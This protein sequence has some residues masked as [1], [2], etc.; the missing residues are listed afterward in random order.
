MIP[1]LFIQFFLFLFFSSSNSPWMA[2]SNFLVVIHSSWEMKC[3]MLA[4][5]ER[6]FDCKTFPTLELFSIWH[7]F[8]I[9]LKLN[10][11]RQS[12]GL[13]SNGFTMISISS[14]FKSNACSSVFVRYSLQLKFRLVIPFYLPHHLKVLL[15]KSN[16]IYEKWEFSSSNFLL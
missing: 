3:S 2:K 7:E 8:I 14:T 13:I 12:A 9:A 16:S 5:D 1:T 15:T 6:N 4:Y 11:L 10:K